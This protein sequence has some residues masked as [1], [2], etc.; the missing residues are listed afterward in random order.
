MKLVDFLREEFLTYSRAHRDWSGTNKSYSIYKNPTKREVKETTKENNP[1][2]DPNEFKYILD[3]KKK[4]IY[5][6][7]S[8]VIHEEVFNYLGVSLYDRS[9]NDYRRGLGNLKDGKIKGTNIHGEM[10]EWAM[11]FFK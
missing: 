6:F 2:S 10:P 4:D 9:S 11:G 5:V 1:N 3:I 8:S 7:T